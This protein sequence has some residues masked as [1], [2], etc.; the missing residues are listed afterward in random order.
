MAHSSFTHPN[1]LVGMA[2][3]IYRRGPWSVKV[4]PC[5]SDEFMCEWAVES[6]EPFFYFYETLFSKLGITL[7][8]HRV[9]A[10][11]PTQLHPNNWA[12]VWAF[13]LLSEDLGRE[14][15]L[16]T[17]LSSRP[18]QKLMMSFCESYKQFK[19]HFC[20]VAAS[21]SRPSMLYNNV[22]DSLFPL[23]WTDQLAIS[24]SVDRNEMQDWEDKFVEEL[25]RISLL[26]CSKLIINKG[27]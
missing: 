25:D 23:Y 5:R 9:R 2:D 11:P 27:G 13:E 15:S 19:E 18:W 3:A 14:P 6:E 7:P 17:S 4:L 8:L 20:R 21:R 12:F 10:S 16:G 26:S 24:V 1:K 22:G